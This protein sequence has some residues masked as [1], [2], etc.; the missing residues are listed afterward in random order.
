MDPKIVNDPQYAQ[1]AL[2]GLSQ[3]PTL[4]VGVDPNNIF[5]S[6][7]FYDTPR[8][9][10]HAPVPISFEY[11][12]PNNPRNNVGVGAGISAH[13]D[14]GLKR[15]F[16]IHFSR[17][18]GGPSK[19]K[20]RIF[21]SAPLRGGGGSSATHEFDDLIL[22]AGNHRSWANMS[23]PARTTYTE[24]EYVRDTQ[25]AMTGQGTHGMFVHL[26]ING[27]YWGL[28]NLVER[29][30]EGYGEAYF[31]SKKGDYFSMSNNRVKS[32]DATRWSYMLDTLCEQDMSVSANYAQMQ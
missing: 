5:G 18:Y 23:A 30:D 32:G 28:Y 25:I 7:G 9:K 3:I 14:Q 19:L 13:G 31:N 4:S 11:I 15:S 29:L 8:K 16:H 22:R 10:Y 26:Y 17:K 27:I 20:A 1:Q 6:R 24:D 21:E 12:D 2:Q